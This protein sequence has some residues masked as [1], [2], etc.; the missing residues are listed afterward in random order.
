MSDAGPAITR[1]DFAAGGLRGTHLTLYPN[2]LVHR[3]YA[4]LE[5]LPLASIASVRVAFE[6]D[7]RKL[8]WGAV[9][10]I[11]ALLLLG[12]AAPL[13]AFAGGAA[14]ELAAGGTQGVGRA[15]QGF[16]RVIE[17]L[18]NALPLLAMVVVLGGI[19]LGVLGWLGS[20]KLTLTLAGVERVYPVR[21]RDAR[22]LDFAEALSER[23]VACV[24]VLRR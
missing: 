5:T 7:E 21:G 22:L 4:H 16:F 10:V 2:C 3:G 1:F 11:I 24:M 12:I 14:V 23:V 15:L 20:T 9:L 18:A 6:R 17:A 8:G 13:A 19:A